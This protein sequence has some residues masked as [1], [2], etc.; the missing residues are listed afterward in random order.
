MVLTKPIL[1]GETKMTVTNEET[2]TTII[3][4]NTHP[5]RVCL[6][7]NDL[8]IMT[9]FYQSVIG[10]SIVR[11]EEGAVYFNSGDHSPVLLVLQQLKSPKARKQTSGLFHVAFLLPTRKDLGNVL[12]SLIRKNV[13][14]QGASNHGYSEAI[15]LADPEGNG[16]EIYRDKPISEWNIQDDGTI[17]GITEAM[18]ADGVLASRDD[19]SD[20]F[21]IGT[22][23]GH[24]HLSVI[25]LNKTQDFYANL[26]G[27]TLKD[28]FGNQAKF[29][30]AG[31]YHHHIGTN[32]WGRATK[33]LEEG[34]LGL[35]Y[36]TLAVPNHS[37]LEQLATVLD[38]LHQSYQRDTVGRIQLKD[39]NGITLLIE[40]EEQFKTL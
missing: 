2:L 25:D 3:P 12:A 8:R 38:D 5:G 26:L 11:K 1:R 29:F 7:V 33:P 36:F 20:Q 6:S 30:A 31:N 15:Y 37:D 9:D 21:P 13:P 17:H 10:L 23:V 27:L 4:A 28:N 39:P 24:V 14:L 18:D 34:D 19:G 40:T 35:R 16:I 32:T 22:T